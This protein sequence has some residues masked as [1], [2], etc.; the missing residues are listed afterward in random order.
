MVDVHAGFAEGHREG[1]GGSASRPRSFFD[2]EVD[3]LVGLT[4][5]FD[6][7]E[8]VN[9]F[10]TVPILVLVVDGKVNAKQSASRAIGCG[11]GHISR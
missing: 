1:G 4:G 10:L 5:V 9:F 7:D 11:G 6:L 3:G 2:S 8:V